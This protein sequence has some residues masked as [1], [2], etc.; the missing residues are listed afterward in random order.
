[1][2][3]FVNIHLYSEDPSWTQATLPVDLGGLGIRS[4]VSIAPSAFLASSNASADL[5]WAILPSSL[6]SLPVP[7]IEEALGVWSQ[8]HNQQRPESVTACKS[9]G[10]P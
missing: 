5:V 6:V 7:E 3:S 2:S 8:G 10:T 1:M 9:H 4:A